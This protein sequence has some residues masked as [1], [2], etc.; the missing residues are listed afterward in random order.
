MVYTGN[1]CVD[2]NDTHLDISSRKQAFWWRMKREWAEL[3]AFFRVA[4]SEGK[5]IQSDERLRIVLLQFKTDCCVRDVFY[6]SSN[7]NFIFLLTDIKKE[8]KKRS[9]M[10]W[11]FS[12][13]NK[14]E[15]AGSWA[16][17]R[18]EGARGF[19]ADFMLDICSILEPLE[20]LESN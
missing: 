9:S 14:R 11:L 3:N 12:R 5:N 7:W 19:Y 6:T 15:A 18:K 4:K 2:H 10:S 20:Q 13:K 17:W 16:C 1:W 8:K